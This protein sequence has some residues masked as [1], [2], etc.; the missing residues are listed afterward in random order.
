MIYFLKG[1]DGLP[2][3]NLTQQKDLTKKEWFEYLLKIKQDFPAN[4]LCAG[5]KFPD[6]LSK[7]MEKCENLKFD[8]EP[9]YDG[10]QSLLREVLA[11]KGFEDSASGHHSLHSED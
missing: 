9:D 7:F 2:W 6:Q 11:E 10:L 4:K 8:E 1:K 3:Q 5:S